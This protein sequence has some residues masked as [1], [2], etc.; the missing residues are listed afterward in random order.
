VRAG[1]PKWLYWILDS[2]LRRHRLTTFASWWGGVEGKLG[3]Q[4]SEG[5]KSSERVRV[6]LV[7]PI[8]SESLLIQTDG[9]GNGVTTVGLLAKTWKFCKLPLDRGP[10]VKTLLGEKGSQRAGQW[11]RLT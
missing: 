5:Q 7:S 6:P 1:A 10:S 3:G 4:A 9:K 8:V 11:K 2:E